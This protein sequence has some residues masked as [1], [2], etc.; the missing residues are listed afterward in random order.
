MDS[1]LIA[2]KQRKLE[3]QDRFTKAQEAYGLAVAHKHPQ[4]EL[5]AAVDACLAAAYP[6]YEALEA[7]RDYLLLI[8]H[9]EDV[10]VELDRN[11]RLI[12]ALTQ[13]TEALAKL[14]YLHATESEPIPNPPK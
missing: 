6:Y 10:Q 2:L 4:A 12:D 3:K 1:T 13:Q 8:S 11:R 9:I 5:V 14:S 7:L